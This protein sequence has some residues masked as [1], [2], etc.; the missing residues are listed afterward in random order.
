MVPEVSAKPIGIVPMLRLSSGRQSWLVGYWGRPCV[1][2]AGVQAMPLS[3]PPWQVPL[4]GV[5]MLPP[6]QRAQGWIPGVSGRLSPTR[7]ISELSG[8]SICAVPS[9]QSSVPE[10][11]AATV[12]MTQVLV[13]VVAVLGIGS[14]PPKKQ[15]TSLQKRSV[16]VCVDVDAPSVAVCPVQAVISVM[17]TEWFGVMAGSGTELAPPP[18]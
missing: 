4:F 2:L 10:A 14:G 9:A 1:V 13:G 7:K 8:R 18:K 17:D 3:C 6:V 12:L 5:L 15:P 11:G 16:P